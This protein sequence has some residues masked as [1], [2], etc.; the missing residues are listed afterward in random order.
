[1]IS[2]FNVSISGLNAATRRISVAADNIANQSSTATKQDGQ[3]IDE[4]FH[5]KV[6]Q[7]ISQGQGG[8]SVVVKEANPPIITTFDPTA[9]NADA[10]GQSRVP[11]VDVAEQL[12][13]QRIAGYDYKANLKS[14]QVQDN[15]LK[16]LLDIKS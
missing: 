10:N 7:S 2:S 5:A 1:M 14:I 13:N 15:M 9:P 4:P 6:A 11:N 8:V 3:V 12:I 16:N